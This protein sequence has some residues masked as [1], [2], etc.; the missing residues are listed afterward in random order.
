MQFTMRI[1]FSSLHQALDS[2]AFPFHPPTDDVDADCFKIVCI[3]FTQP[4]AVDA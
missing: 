2:A 3:R 4:K 1:I